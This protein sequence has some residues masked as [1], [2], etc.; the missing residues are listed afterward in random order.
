[1][2]AS[3]LHGSATGIRRLALLCAP[4]Y[5]HGRLYT[6]QVLTRSGN[7][8]C[9]VESGRYEILRTSKNNTNE[10]HDF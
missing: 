2:A 9:G 4:A 1:M 7:R 5:R 6:S 10:L 8:H 3:D